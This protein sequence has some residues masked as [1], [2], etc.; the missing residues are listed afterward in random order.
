MIS[1]VIAGHSFRGSILY[2]LQERKHA[3]VLKVEGVR[4]HDKKLMIEDFVR[5]HQ[6]RPEKRQACF[7]S[8][9]SFYPGEKPSDKLITQIADEYLKGLNIKDTQFAVIKHT[10]KE[11]LHVHIIANMV[12]NHGKTVS[13]NWIGLRGKKQ[14]QRLTVEHKLVRALTK[15]LELTHRENLRQ[16]EQYQYKIYEA[17]K[18]NLPACRSMEEL[19]MRLSKEGIETLYKYKGQTNE[20]QGISFK[21]GEYKFKGSKIDRQLSL[22]NLEKTIALQQKMEMKRLY[23]SIQSGK[24][25][26][27][28]LSQSREENKNAVRE[29]LKAPQMKMVETFKVYMNTPDSPQ[30]LSPELIREAQ[31]KKKRQHLSR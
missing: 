28:P 3:Q 4:G 21:R 17:I 1:K 23:Q 12:N 11:H 27:T 9:L 19:Q 24:M 31:R 30:S 25:L 22:T 2:I 6:L 7:H 20:K 5:Q 16:P 10:D 8:V 14:A 18:K 15:K 29:F 13:D 26:A